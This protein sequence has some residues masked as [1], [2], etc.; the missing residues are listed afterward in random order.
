MTGDGRGG[1][2]KAGFP[3]RPQPLEIANNAIPTFPQPRRGAEKWKTKST[4]PTFPLAVFSSQTNQKGGLAAD[5]FAPA[6]RLILRLENALPTMNG[7]KSTRM[8]RSPQNLVQPSPRTEW[9]IRPACLHHN[10][11]ASEIHTSAPIALALSEL[12][13]S[14]VSLF[15]PKA[16]RVMADD[17]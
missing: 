9:M 11:D 7:K 2:P 10:W 13:D 12:N 1:K 17:L 14:V 8:S 6:S 5:R 3:P 16:A 4:F 15:Q